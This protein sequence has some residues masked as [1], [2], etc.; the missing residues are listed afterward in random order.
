MSRAQVALEVVDVA[1][2]LPVWLEHLP[3]RQN[4]FSRG[5][6]EKNILEVVA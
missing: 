5:H 2:V 1:V 4:T 6:W 3:S